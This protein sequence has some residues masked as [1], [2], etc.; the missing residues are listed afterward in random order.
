MGRAM[1]W[2]FFPDKEDTLESLGTLGNGGLD[3]SEPVDFSI[4]V[5]KLLESFSMQLA[6]C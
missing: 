4:P 6:K 5:A 1:L 3:L 2:L